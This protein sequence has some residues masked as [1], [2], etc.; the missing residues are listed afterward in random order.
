MTWLLLCGSL[1]IWLASTYLTL[2]VFARPVADK[3][4]LPAAL[5]TLAV[6]AYDT[7]RVEHVPR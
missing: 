2:A 5:A 4:L 3:L 1:R 6:F 7:W